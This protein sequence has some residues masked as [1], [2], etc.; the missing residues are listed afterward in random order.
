MSGKAPELE[1]TAV[2]SCTRVEFGWKGDIMVVVLEELEEL[3][4]SE[5]HAKRLNAKEVRMPQ[6]G[7]NSYSQS[8]ME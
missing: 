8:Q 7:A 6:N 4:A 5:I 2:T 1:R 3:D